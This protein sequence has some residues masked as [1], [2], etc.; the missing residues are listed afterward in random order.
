M[1]GNSRIIFFLY[2]KGNRKLLS[3]DG[4]PKPEDITPLI[5]SGGNEK[6]IFNA[7]TFFPFSEAKF[8]IGDDFLFL[9]EIG[10]KKYESPIGFTKL[11]IPCFPG[12]T[13]VKIEVHAEGDMG[14]IVDFSFPHEPVSI[15]F[16]NVGSLPASVH[17]L[18]RSKVA[19]S[20]PIN[21]I[22]SSKISL[23]NVYTP[24]YFENC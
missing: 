11:K 15:R 9:D 2:S 4:A 12:F 6:G 20:N 18:I 24:L 1:F 23:S 19:P 13:P 21:K 5:L 8:H 16:L 3:F 7:I 14:G 22:F 10:V 17:D